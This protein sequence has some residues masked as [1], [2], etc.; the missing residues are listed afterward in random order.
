M[1]KGDT[2]EQLSTFTT[3][4][5]P[6][7]KTWGTKN[8]SSWSGNFRLAL[9]ASQYVNAPVIKCPNYQNKTQNKTRLQTDTKNGLGLCV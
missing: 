9:K 3:W 4:Q 7:L 2:A 6:L 1:S 5:M 8:C